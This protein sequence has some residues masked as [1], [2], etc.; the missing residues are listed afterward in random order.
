M[1]NRQAGNTRGRA[2]S[3]SSAVYAG[4]LASLDNGELRP[5][6]RLPAE[7]ELARAYD[8]SRPTVRKAL[9]QLRQDKRIESRRG[10]GSYALLGQR[11]TSQPDPVI[12]DIRPCLSFRLAVE[13]ASAAQAA[14]RHQSEDMTDI[15]ACMNSLE[16]AWAARDLEAFIKADMAFHLAIASMSGNPYLAESLRSNQH[17]IL[18]TMRI[19]ALKRIGGVSHWDRRVLLEH[20]EILSAI[21]NGSSL[22][23]IEAMTQHLGSARRSLSEQSIR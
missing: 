22:G 17:Q 13:C 21:R 9:E 20:A 12:E 14:D 16:D 2:G 18:R 4:I 3:L 8:V 10:S 7:S 23:A 15:T 19:C 6:S 5:G 1:N 11:V